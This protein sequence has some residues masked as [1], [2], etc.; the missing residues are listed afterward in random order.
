MRRKPNR[1]AG[2]V[3]FNVRT[4]DFHVFRAKAVIVSA[5]GASH[6][7]KPRAVGE[8][9]GR[10]WYAPWSSASA[11]GLPILVGAKMTQMENRIVLTRF[12]DGYG[13]VG[14][15]FLHL[16]TYTAERL[17]RGV[18]VEVERAHQGAGGRLHRPASGAD[19]P[20]QPRAARGG[21]R[22]VAARSAW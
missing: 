4:G 3:G 1:V 17:R 9:M 19:L 11:Y 16:K 18:R 14:A 2:A 13:P 6:I 5:G 21:R 22:P 8:G 10:T 7:F 12:K 15:Y 20:A